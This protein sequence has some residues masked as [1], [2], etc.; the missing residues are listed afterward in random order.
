MLAVILIGLAEILRLYREALLE[1]DE[2]KAQ[3]MKKK[4]FGRLFKLLED[5][6]EH[7]ERE[8]GDVEIEEWEVK[9]DREKIEKCEEKSFTLEITI[10]INVS[11]LIPDIRIPITLEFTFESF[12]QFMDEIAEWLNNN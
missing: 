11:G 10:A 2:K 6:K 4:A 9:G 8:F 1:E 3:K 12:V 7:V 5:L